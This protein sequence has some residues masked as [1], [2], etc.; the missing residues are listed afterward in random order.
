MRSIRRITLIVA[1]AAVLCGS[2]LLVVLGYDGVFTPGGCSLDLGGGIGR[3]ISSLE[4]ESTQPGSSEVKE[5]LEDPNFGASPKA[6]RDLKTGVVDERLVATLQ[7]VTKKHRICV[8]AFK[9]GHYFSP[10]VPD[11]PFI[12]ANYGDAGGLPNTHYYGRAADIREVDGKFVRGNGTDPDILDVGKII[13]DIPSQQRPDQIIGPRSWA[14]SLGSSR[15]EG[16]ILDADQLKL[17]E[18]HLHIGY[19]SADGTRNRR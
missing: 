6:I 18:D 13:A 11:G 15:Q 7:A 16:W 9:E 12:P 19:M 1:A 2:V 5:L 4:G 14:E 3:V 8:D 10:G 17:H